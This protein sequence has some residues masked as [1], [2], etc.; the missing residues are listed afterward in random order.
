MDMTERTCCDVMLT[1]NDLRVNHG[2]YIHGPPMSS[3]Y[4]LEDNYSTMYTT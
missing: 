3:L 2:V 4:A 1:Q